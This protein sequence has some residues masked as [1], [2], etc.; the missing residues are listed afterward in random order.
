[1]LDAI[2]T[3]LSELSGSDEKKPLADDDYRLAAAALLFHVIAVD[4][5]VSEEERN[6]LAELLMRRYQ[7]D[8][9]GVDELIARAETADN[10]AID[11]YGFTHILKQKLDAA[12][13]ERI[14]ELMWM[15]VYADGSAHEFEDNVIWRVAEL[16]GVSSQ[17]RIRLKCATVR[18]IEY[19]ENPCWPRK[20]GA[21]L[22]PRD[23]DV[24]HRPSKR[25]VAFCES[26]RRM[27]RR[28]G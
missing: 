16:L 20:R 11:L 14:I 13:R 3:F 1:M 21:K 6:K 4:G 10:E 23:D 2:K 18:P 27:R 24:A 12:G 17:D 8:R 26:C 25:I 5:V 7:L 22:D 19:A 15:L 28:P 9:A